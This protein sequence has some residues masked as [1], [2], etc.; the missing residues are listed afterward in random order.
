MDDA[1]G[2]TAISNVPKNISPID[3]VSAGLRPARSEYGPMTRAPSGRTRKETAKVPKGRSKET[4][5]F[6]GSSGEA[7]RCR[8]MR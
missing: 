5:A 3:S 6:P 1:G 4:P 8:L 2:I 7:P